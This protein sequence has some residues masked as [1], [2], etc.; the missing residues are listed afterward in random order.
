MALWVCFVAAQSPSST[1]T[2]TANVHTG[3]YAALLSDVS[4]CAALATNA[5]V[6]ISRTGGGTLLGYYMN[7]YTADNDPCFE[8]AVVDIPRITCVDIDMSSC[9]AATFGGWGSQVLLNVKLQD[10][11]TW[12][13]THLPR[14]GLTFLRGLC[15]QTSL[16]PR[17]PNGHPECVGPLVYWR[18]LG[19][20]LTATAT[21]TSSSTGT[22]TRSQSLTSTTS[23]SG[24]STATPRTKPGSATATSSATATGTRTSTASA[25]PSTS[26][27]TTRSS[28]ATA[29]GTGTTTAIPPGHSPTST[30]SSQPS[31]PTSSAAATQ[32]STATGSL[33]AT[34]TTSG[35]PSA[36]QSP[37]ATP[38]PTAGWLPN[39][40]S[41][42]A[43][44]DS[45]D[46]DATGIARLGVLT[47]WKDKSGHGGDT[48][49]QR[50]AA[51]VN[52]SGVCMP[53]TAIHSTPIL[54]DNRACVQG[55]TLLAVY[56]RPSGPLEYVV[57]TWPTSSF[58]SI[59]DSL[60]AT[61]IGVPKNAQ[62]DFGETGGTTT[63]LRFATSSTSSRM[64]YTLTLA[65][66]T[67]NTITN[68]FL[69]VNGGQA[70]QA[71]TA[72]GGYL[73]TSAVWAF[74][75]NY[76]SGLCYQEVLF[77]A[78]ALPPYY[79]QLAEGYLAWRWG[80]VGELPETHPWKYSPPYLATLSAT[81]SATGT[82][83]ARSVTATAS[84]SG[85]AQ[86][87]APPGTVTAT[88]SAT[89][90]A[91]ATLSS[92]STATAT[93]SA[94]A[95]ASASSSGSSTSSA[96][97][98]ATATTTAANTPWSPLSIGGCTLWL[99]G[100]DAS[101]INYTT[102]PSVS[103]WSDKSSSGFHAIAKGTSYPTYAN[104]QV[105]FADASDELVSSNPQFSN[106]NITVFIVYTITN[107]KPM[108]VVFSGCNPTT[109]AVHGWE[110]IDLF[111]GDAMWTNWESPGIPVYIGAS[112]V[113][114]RRRLGLIMDQRVPTWSVDGGAWLS[115]NQQYPC[116]T[117]AS[118]V[119]GGGG[120]GTFYT[121]VGNLAEMIVYD[122]V[123]STTDRAAMD[124]YLADRWFNVSYTMRPR[125]MPAATCSAR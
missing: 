77:F 62:F 112:T 72:K 21:G 124:T 74:G 78:N 29:T 39:Q 92:T 107:A 79:Y 55:V 117:P 83:V 59:K 17:Y 64:L 119:I 85:S 69:S 52:S 49:Q 47:S 8:T 105:T 48:V 43:W 24:T 1:P 86:P 25:R 7:L 18:H 106:D 20:A 9:S 27:Q 26:G 16:C 115:G 81:A 122:R 50:G 41:P 121:F 10:D 44:Y 91:T 120:V 65:N 14:Q 97:G 13:Q 96:S 42:L 110:L 73:G 23:A 116:T 70:S 12:S 76:G 28:T 67:C 33:T 3:A 93:L 108:Q 80:L 101:T 2:P 75:P 30:H 118:L 57:R 38:S 89:G 84:T 68:L 31:L 35:S 113:N 36:S 54:R 19:L 90:S 95:T 99:D 5:T 109:Y 66:T 94:T 53:L 71:A 82:T 11:G 111:N 56:D 4:T 123:I 98:T 46:P 103:Q 6:L 40:L 102:S 51:L 100:K 60:Y 22:A 88:S 58:W 15:C 87:T 32:T 63:T 125:G 61:T 34:A 104:D 37:S 114:V 45:R